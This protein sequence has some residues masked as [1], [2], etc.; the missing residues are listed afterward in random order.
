MAAFFSSLAFRLLLQLL[1]LALLPN[2]TSTFAYKSLG[3]SIDLIHRNSSL[4]PLYDP[5]FT[6]AQRAKQAALRSRHI[7]SRFANTTSMISSPVMPGSGEYLIKLSLGT[8]SR[9]YWATLDTGSDLIWTTYRPC[10]SCSGQTSIYSYEDRSFIEGILATETLVFDNGAST[11]ELPG[12]VFGCV[13]N[14][15]A[16]NPAFLEVPGLVGLCGG[17]LKFGEDAE[18][19]G[20]EEIQETPMA[21]GGSQG[22]Y[23]VLNLTDISVG[24]NRLNIQF[25]GAQTTALLGDAR[26]IITD[27]GTTLTYLAKEM[28]DLVANAVANVTNQERFY[29][30]EQDLLCYHVENNGDPYEGLP[31]MTFHFSN[32]DWKL[33]PSN[34]FRMF[35][36]GIACLTNKDGEMPIFGNLAQQNMHVKYDLG[37]KLLSF[38]P[39]ECTQG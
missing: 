26:S 8:P 20:K 25:G 16:P 15:G 19:S 27:S 33:P 35:G 12:I 29:P 38:A 21:P 34:I 24:D 14:E 23:Y 37:N 7:A 17:Q 3:I 4:C 22:T 11:M 31:E 2:P 5:S 10:D 18:F 13:H 28:C 36:T 39:T 6:L 9:P 30:P 1:L 32:A